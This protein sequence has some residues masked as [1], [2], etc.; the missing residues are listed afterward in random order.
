MRRL[1]GLFAER[2]ARLRGLLFVAVSLGAVLAGYGAVG[3]VQAGH[4]I[5]RFGYY[6]IL[7]V[8][9]LFVVYARRLA[10]QRAE[11]WRGWLRHPG[12]GGAAVVLGTLFALWSDTFQHKIL[13]DEYVIQGTAY[14]MHAMKQ[15][16]TVIRAYDLQGTW[17]ILDPYLDKRP[18]FFPFLVSLLHDL[19]GYR[20]GNLFAVN[21]ACAAALLGLLY[22]FARELAGR[23]PAILAVALMAVLPLFGQNA[24]GAGM[25]LHNLT[26]IAL[27]A[28]LGTLYLK[29]PSDDRLSLFVLGSVLLTQSRYESVIFILPV[30][31][32]VFAG[33]LRAGRVILPW[34][35]IGAPLLFVPYAWH[36]KVLA[37]EPVFWQL[38]EG[39]TSPFGLDNV[40]SNF[41]G[42][43]DFLFNTGPG[44]ANSWILSV[45]GLLGLGWLGWEAWVWLR[46]DRPPLAPAA[47]VGIAFGLGVGVHFLILLFYWWAKFD[48]LMASRFALPLCLSFAILAAALVGALSRRRIPALPVAWTALAAWLLLAGMPAYNLRFYTV[49]NLG[50]Q[51]IAWERSVLRGSPGPLLV[52]SNKSTLPF[53][54]SRTESI[55]KDVAVLRSD[56]LRFHMQQET[57]RTVVVTQAVRPTPGGGRGVD[58]EDVMPPRF[59]LEFIAER[60]FGDSWDRISRVVSVDP[61]P[62]E[63][64]RPPPDHRPS[65]LRSISRLQSRRVPSVASA[66]SA[67][68][69]R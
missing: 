25:D 65:D 10:I 56:D 36:S 7:G 44:L 66:T 26:M 19:T 55:L 16:S 57:F 21:V 29:A 41:R 42:D 27:V 61:A 39:Q 63:P 58:P 2:S 60:R 28:C 53:I 12:A 22:W 67:A 33:W 46:R 37:A 40:A 47:F 6:Y 51:Q 17:V 24:T 1:V 38:K 43:V 23:R 5:I 3:H 52:I 8:F 14:V 59:H 50:M 45:A 18:Y 62:A 32:V 31:A 30:A 11:V 68:S 35:V 15:V 20:L 69:S 9:W 64:A 4:L 34:V 54:L 13:Y 48:D 49:H